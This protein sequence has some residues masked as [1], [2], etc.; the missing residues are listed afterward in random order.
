MRAGMMTHS[1]AHSE[2]RIRVILWD[3]DGTLTDFASAEREA[4]RSGFETFGY[5]PC[6]DEML[7]RYAA[8]NEACWKRI[9]KEKVDKAAFLVQ[10]FV[11]FF[12]DAGL[13]T[14]RAAEFNHYYQLALGDTI[15][16]N[17]NSYELVKSLRGKVLQYIVTNGTREAQENKLEKSGFDALADG[18]FISEMTG[19]DKPADGYFEY[20]FDR[21]EACDR[22]EILIVGDSLT[23]DMTGGLNQGIVT[24]WYNPEAHPVPEDMAIDYDLRDLNEV[25]AIVGLNA[26][27]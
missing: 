4:I 26:A 6:D 20:V 10:R 22:R 5:G 18:A 14:D 16:Y 7:K 19:Y 25:K 21:I 12:E 15:I 8:H 2:D 27:G 17:D 11:D 23:S 13:P 24:A 1:T 3:L 9:E